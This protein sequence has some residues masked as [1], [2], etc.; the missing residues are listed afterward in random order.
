MRDVPSGNLQPGESPV[1]RLGALQAL[2]PEF[3]RV[4]DVQRGAMSADVVRQAGIV[5][6]LLTE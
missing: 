6:R 2:A 1:D 4:A 5:Q 3:H